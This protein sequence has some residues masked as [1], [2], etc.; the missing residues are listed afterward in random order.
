M[1]PPHVP[2]SESPPLSSSGPRWAGWA[3]GH[4]LALL[5]V[6]LA[7]AGDAAAQSVSASVSAQQV[8][9]GDT[10]VYTVTLNGGTHM[11]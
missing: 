8:R 9:M 3:A 10:V 5:I 6:G 4:L 7:I 1:R 2:G 11:Y